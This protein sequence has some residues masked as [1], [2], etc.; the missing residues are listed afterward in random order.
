MDLVKYV[1]CKSEDREFRSSVFG[2]W[3]WIKV[4]LEQCYWKDE[5]AGYTDVVVTDFIKELPVTNLAPLEQDN[6]TLKSL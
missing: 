6:Y 4:D 2:K 1:L 3:P 5:S